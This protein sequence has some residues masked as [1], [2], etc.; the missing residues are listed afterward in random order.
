MVITLTECTDYNPSDFVNEFIFENNVILAFYYG[1][2]GFT[3]GYPIEDMYSNMYIS[4][5][6]V[7]FTQIVPMSGNLSAITSML[8]F[9][10]IPKS[11]FTYDPQIEYSF[12][13]TTNR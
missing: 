5:N 12:E 9:V 2:I 1:H 6:Q 8:D 11:N 13:T 7:Y 3:V 10:I 4:G